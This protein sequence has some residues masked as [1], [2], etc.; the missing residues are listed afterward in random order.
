MDKEAFDKDKAEIISIV[1]KLKKESDDL[2][3]ATTTFLNNLDNEKINKK[4]YDIFKNAFLRIY[5]LTGGIH[6]MNDYINSL[7]KKNILYN[8]PEGEKT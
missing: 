4:N 1:S 8:S 2:E 6:G 5:G 7:D 3:N